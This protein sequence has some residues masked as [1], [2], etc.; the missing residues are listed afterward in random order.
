MHGKKIIDL[1]SYHTNI[2]YHQLQDNSPQLPW[3]KHNFNYS[4]VDYEVHYIIGHSIFCL[5]QYRKIQ[6]IM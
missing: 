4:V 5:L 6:S 2:K 3:Q 1:G